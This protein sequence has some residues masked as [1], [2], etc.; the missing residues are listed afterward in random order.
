M[1]RTHHAEH[2]SPHRHIGKHKVHVKRR[3]EIR[4]PKRDPDP[5]GQRDDEEA[6]PPVIYRGFDAYD[7]AS[8]GYAVGQPTDNRSTATYVDE[9]DD[10]NGAEASE[11]DDLE[12]DAF[13]P[14]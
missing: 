13:S 10:A 4:V 11:I 3:E 6:P 14:S 9:R 5:P 2:R 7:V 12:I 1:L 8:Y